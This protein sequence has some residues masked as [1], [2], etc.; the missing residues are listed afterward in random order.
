MRADLQ[1][2]GQLFR[3]SSICIMRNMH[4]EVMHYEILYCNGIYGPSGCLPEEKVSGHAL[5]SL[6]AAK[7]SMPEAAFE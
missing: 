5:P 1:W 4:Y 6:E 7:V 3:G 2:T